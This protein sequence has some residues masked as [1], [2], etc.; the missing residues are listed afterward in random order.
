MRNEEVGQV[1]CGGDFVPM[2]GILECLDLSNGLTAVTLGE[3]DIIILV[4]FE[5][6]VKIYEV[7]RL[8]FDIPSE[9]FQVIAII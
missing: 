8:I 2:P 7:N 9:Y 4:T 6:R 5:R 3:E 1:C